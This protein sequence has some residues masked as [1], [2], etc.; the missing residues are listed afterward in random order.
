MLTT[1]I[2]TKKQLTTEIMTK[3][4]RKKPKVVED[5]SNAEFL[6]VSSAVKTEIVYEDTKV[7]TREKLKLKWG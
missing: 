3:K 1:E 2:M 6:E 5:D 7:I 4:A